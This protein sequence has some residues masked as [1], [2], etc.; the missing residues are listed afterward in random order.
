[1]KNKMYKSKNLFLSI[2]ALL[3]ILLIGSK[4]VNEKNSEIEQL[5][6][7]IVS[8]ENS[9]ALKDKEYKAEE[10]E[11]DLSTEETNIENLYDINN[12][13]I[14][15]KTYKDGNKKKTL[16]LISVDKSLCKDE[17]N[18]IPFYSN[19]NYQKTII[20]FYS[21]LGKEYLGFMEY[22]IIEEDEMS[23][24]YFKINYD[25]YMI[26]QRNVIKPESMKDYTYYKNSDDIE[27]KIYT[28]KDILDSSLI[29]AKY[30]LKDLLKIIIEL[31]K[32]IEINIEDFITN[33]LIKNK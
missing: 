2:I 31:D 10:P 19:Q 18:D 25:G 23:A 15:E 17:F 32:D 22:I 29:K 21:V 9:L 4:I 26:E 20:S 28:L 6:E 27:I 33:K 8:L 12:L 13:R 24:T 11:E 1:M 5:E 3:S 30:T 14:I 16:V 7:K